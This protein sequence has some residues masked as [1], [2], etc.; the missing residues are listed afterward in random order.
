VKNQIV[1]T[2]L[3]AM[4][5]VLVG[6]HNPPAMA[7][8]T[9]KPESA[10]PHNSVVYMNLLDNAIAS[11][12]ERNQRLP[13]SVNDLI[14]G[15]YL[16]WQPLVD[17]SWNYTER[18][19]TVSATLT[20]RPLGEGDKDWS[21]DYFAPGTAEYDAV[22]ERHAKNRLKYVMRARTKDPTAFA[23]LSD[24]EILAGA[25]LVYSQEQ[26]AAVAASVSDRE[27]IL[28]AYNLRSE[29]LMLTQ[30]FCF[31]VGR[32]PHDFG[33]LSEFVGEEIDEG[34]V[35]PKLGLRL[36]PGEFA[37]FDRF[38]YWSNARDNSVIIRVPSATDT[39][40]KYVYGAFLV[41]PSHAVASGF[42]Y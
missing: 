30:A 8:E 31:S 28:W 29:L 42:Y 37:A 24:E 21:H 36:Q 23:G 5:M 18:K 33:E 41:G 40:F 3:A 15:G 7:N 38:Q 2:I 1:I 11:F 32:L 27:A 20:T 4:L 13:G 22:Q 39:V 14:D 34:F 35:H 10:L 16:R 6:T 17:Y 9:D 12:I 25:G 26:M 19:L